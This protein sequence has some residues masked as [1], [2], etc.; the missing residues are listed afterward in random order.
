MNTIPA[1]PAL[2]AMAGPAVIPAG[3]AAFI[4]GPILL[5]CLVSG[6]A[7]L[8]S[9]L[10]AR[11]GKQPARATGTR[12]VAAHHVSTHHIVRDARK[13]RRAKLRRQAIGAVGDWQLD[14]TATT[15]RSPR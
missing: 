3:Y 13:P 6:L 14:R 5:L 15:V 9:L 7:L 4:W 12:P 10:Q 11:L 8:A 2:E 1:I